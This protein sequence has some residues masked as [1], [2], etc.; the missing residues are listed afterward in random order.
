MTEPQIRYAT[1][2][3]GVKLSFWT[4]GTGRPFVHLTLGTVALRGEFEIPE[5]RQWYERLAE[6]WQLVRF[7]NRGEG[8]SDRA[9]K[10]R[11][12]E[13]GVADLGAVVDQLQLDRFVLFAPWYGGPPAIAYTALHPERVSHL[14]LWCTF[15]RGKEWLAQQQFQAVI[16]LADKDWTAYT[17]AVAHAMFGWSRGAVANRHAAILR[18]SV[19][20]EFVRGFYS[21]VSRWDVSGYLERISVP[22]LVLQREQHS[23]DIDVASGLAASISQAR[24]VM[25]PGESVAPYLENSDAV[26]EVIEEFAAVDEGVVSREATS[27]LTQREMQVLRLVAAGKSN[28]Q[29]AEELVISVN[30][31]DRHVSNILTKIGAANRAEASSF[32]VRH[33]IA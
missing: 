8:L 10:G 20:P 14:I 29:I 22:T 19:S 4:R 30:T 27:M 25:L 9:A 13:D 7:N 2:P 18:E 6:R 1:T 5:C 33:G 15:A 26:I 16:S 23:L 12:L 21:D 17:E 31:A 28:R 11:S 3:D 24:L 32:A